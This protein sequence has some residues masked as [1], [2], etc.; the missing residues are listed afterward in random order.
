ME[1]REKPW[2]IFQE[3]GKIDDYLEYCRSRKIE[4][5]TS[6]TG[7]ADSANATD[8]QWDSPARLKNRRG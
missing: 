5:Y 8:D 3:T 7:G 1:S 2:E 4:M 6:A